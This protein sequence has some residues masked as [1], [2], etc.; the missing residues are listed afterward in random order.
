MSSDDLA[1]TE[2]APPPS[3]TPQP[4]DE[5]VS[6]EFQ[7]AIRRAL[8][9]KQD[10]K[11]REAGSKKR[12][13]FDIQ[14]DRHEAKYV[15]PRHLL[16]QMRNFIRPFCEPDPY[17][18][19]DPPEYTITTL[20]LDNDDYSL[21]LAKEREV[22]ARF[23]LRVRTYGEPGSSPVFLEI[24]RKVRGAI[25]KSRAKIPFEAWGEDLIRSTRV[26]LPFKS[27]GEETAL[28]E[29]LRLTRE[30]DAHPVVLIRYIRESYFGVHDSYAR[31]T[32][33]RHLEYQPTDSWDS[34]GRGGRWIPI[35]SPMTQNKQNRFSGIV[36]ELKTLSDAPL[37]MIDLVEYFNLE[38]TGHCKYS[39]AVWSEAI[40]CGRPAEP[41]YTAELLD[42]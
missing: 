9:D 7:T 18:R 22:T 20:Q 17:G 38:R 14:L 23:K 12:A 31:V 11:K 21:H 42:W 16:P 41:S 28:L 6:E 8:Q 33:D 10:R 19:G 2:P 4:G 35:D 37:W 13:K 1:V 3:L 24:K 29:F 25:T 26:N 36:L 40:F 27:R 15:I 30:I 32:F 34:W 39:N 5:R